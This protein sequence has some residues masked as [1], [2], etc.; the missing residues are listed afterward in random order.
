MQIRKLI[1]LVTMCF[2]TT[3]C[4]EFV[5]REK[6]NAAYYGNKPEN[7]K[8]LVIQY[9]D[10]R[11]KDP[12]SAKYKNW[13]SPVQGAAYVKYAPNNV[14]EYM[15]EEGIPKLEF[16][17]LVCFSVN[18]KNSYG[19]YT[20]FKTKTAVIRDNTVIG[21]EEFGGCTKEHMLK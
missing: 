7:C 18:A 16:G 2:I 13:L 12:D 1:I 20:G 10:R 15:A 8:E 6:L 19:G 3:G 14:L 11:L 9:Y 17:W 4:V 21:I 5:S